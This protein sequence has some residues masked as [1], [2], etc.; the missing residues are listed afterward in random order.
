MNDNMI[1]GMKIMTMA[2][3]TRGG[4]VM[5]NEE[6]VIGPVTYEVVRL[7]SGDKNALELIKENL[8]LENVPQSSFDRRSN[9]KV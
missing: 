1:A 7:Y 6:I 5:N 9:D 8:M 4:V 3:N 2:Q